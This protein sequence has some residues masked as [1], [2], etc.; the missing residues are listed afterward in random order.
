MA[1]HSHQADEFF[2]LRGQNHAINVLSGKKGN[3][4]KNQS[5]QETEA[6]PVS[7]ESQKSEEPRV[8]IHRNDNIVT[9]IEFICT[10]GQRSEIR[11]E[12]E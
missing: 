4:V 9:G 8:I 12:Y 2:D 3:I 5:V 10:C 11:F 7:E 1:Q 6:P